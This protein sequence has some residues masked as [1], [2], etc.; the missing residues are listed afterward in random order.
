MRKKIGIA[1]ALLAAAC[2]PFSAVESRA[3]AYPDREI[4]LVVPYAAGG[5]LDTATRQIQMAFAEQLGVPIMVDNRGG[6]GGQLGTTLAVKEKQD[7]Y[8]IGGM[9]SPHLEFILLLRK[10]DFSIDDFAW[11]GG[12][13]SDPACIRV[14]K[15][16]P[17]NTLEDLV[18]DARS[19]PAESIVFG[20]S[21]LFSDNFVGVKTL[22]EATGVKFRIVDFGGGGPSRVALVGKQIDAVH[23]NV[24]SSLHIASESKVLA[25]QADEN[26]FQE[27]TGNAPT[28]SEALK[29]KVPP[30]GT[31]TLFFT[32]Q[33]LKKQYPDRYDF[34]VDAFKK[35]VHSEQYVSNMN[36]LGIFQNIDYLSPEA[37]DAMVRN[38]LEVLGVFKHLWEK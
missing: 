25:V 15:D 21:S 19:R 30:L 14:H 17:W 28:V 18:Q 22:E 23:T 16:A 29:T 1:L 34:L 5:T 37:L 13:T 11:I 9:A 2:S 7:G 38:N 8:V 3:A 20:V 31:R 6:A 26:K 12:L 10:P 27:L 35:A 24:F 32:T 33:A 36:K 4:R